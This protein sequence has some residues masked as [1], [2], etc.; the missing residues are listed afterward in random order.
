MHKF[1]AL[2]GTIHP[3]RHVSNAVV[4]HGLIAWTAPHYR[5]LLA[6]AAVFVS[7][8]VGISTI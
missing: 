3:S 4:R 5:R 7:I 2:V 6:A 1:V 8:P